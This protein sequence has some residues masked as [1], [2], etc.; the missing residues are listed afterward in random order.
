MN[1]EVRG[2]VRF[3]TTL[4]SEC[5]M[6]PCRGGLLDVAAYQ[7]Q[8]GRKSDPNHTFDLGHS[9]PTPLLVSMPCL[10]GAIY[11]D[12]NHLRSVRHEYIRDLLVACS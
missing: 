3:D 6:K 5:Q 1:M 12:D 4:A 2:L 7:F 11:I 8:A 10:G 9:M